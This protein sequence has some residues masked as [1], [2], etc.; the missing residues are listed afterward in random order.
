[1]TIHRN[2]LKSYAPKARTAFIAA[3]SARAAQFG[4]TADGCFPMTEEGDVVIIDG[5]AY[6]RSVANQR[7]DLEA[8]IRLHGFTQAMEEIAYTWFN[9]F[10]A[11][12]YM[13][14]QEGTYFDH[15]YR[16]LSHPDGGDKPE[17]LQHAEHLELAGLDRDRVVDLRLDGTKDEELYRMILVAQCN[18]LHAAMPF[19]FEKID[20]ETELLLPDHLLRSDSLINDLVNDIDE[21]NW[22]EIEIIGW[23]YQF[24][25][26][27][28][29]DEVIGKVV[30]S[31]DI[32][33]ATQLFTPNWIVKYMV[34]NSLGHQWL[35]TYP[36]SPLKGKMEYYIEPAEQTEEVQAQLAEITPTELNPEELT[37]LDPAAGSGH[38]LVEAYDLF[39]EIYLE[40]GYRR[41]DVPRLILEKN[42]YGLDI[43][44][45]AAQMAG[46]ALIMKACA[47]TQNILDPDNPVKLNVMSIQSSEGLD[48]AQLA[49]DLLPEGGRFEIV[50]SDELPGLETQPMLAVNSTSEVR[51]GT[52]NTLIN[53]FEEAKTFGSLITV[54]E[55]VK[56]ALPAFKRLMNQSFEG[57]MLQTQLHDDAV[58]KLFPL[59]K[60]AE[61]LTRLYDAVVANPPYMGAGGMVGSLKDF[62]TSYFAP[63]K[64]DLYACFLIRCNNFLKNN[65]IQSQINMHTW[66]F[67]P[68]YEDL[69]RLIVQNFQLDTLLHLGSR[70]FEEISG[71]VVQSATWVMRKSKVNE[72]KSQYIKLTQGESYTKQS[73]L[74]NKTYDFWFKDQSS[75]EHLPSCSISYDMP[76]AL[77]DVY[78]RHSRYSDY[79]FSDGLTKTGNND[80]YLRFHWEIQN[81]HFLDID[82]FRICHKGGE[83]QEFYGNNLNLVC[84][85]KDIRGHYKS[86][87]VARITPE[88]LWN[89]S[90]I[91][92]TKISSK[93]PSFRLMEEGHIGE[94]GG[95]VIF[96]KD[97]K[98]GTNYKALMFLNSVVSR[99]ILSIANRSLNIQTNDVLNL[100][101]IEIKSQKLEDTAKEVIHISKINWDSYETSW[102]F[103]NAPLLKE[104]VKQ[105]T[106]EESF[107]NWQ[108]EC[109][110]NVQRI[111]ELEEENNRLCIAEYCLQD[112]LSPDVSEE[113]IT[114][115]RADLKQDIKNLISYSIGCMMGRYSLVEEGLIY[116]NAGNV[117]FDGSRYGEFPADDDGIVPISG[118]D[119]LAFDDD[120]AIRFRDFLKIA[121]SEEN[122]NANLQ[123]VGESLGLKKAETPQDAIRS[124]LSKDFYKDHLK[125]YK[126]RPIYWLFSSGKLKAFECL[127]YLHRYNEG[128]LARMRME[129]VTPLQSRM[130]N[131]IEMLSED[132]KMASSA[133]AKKKQTEKDNLSKQLEE[134][135]K[136][137]E[138]LRHYADKRISLDLDDGVKVN[139]G[140]F[141]NLLAETKAITGKKK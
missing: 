92:W 29:K 72:Y 54:P 55:N 3:V 133:E 141:G 33:A 81:T 8:R 103:K 24:Y 138:E 65:G 112:E 23:L 91:T 102:G 94:T 56:Q 121:W 37:L 93:S 19:L 126:K 105:K 137:D 117:G 51:E 82:K 36:L 7:R 10:M 113:H 32:P 67:L 85:T 50:P 127:V 69:R 73:N 123:F 95:P 27:E 48:A 120:A 9:R 131:R 18:A 53:L 77:I 6:P 57:D 104:K 101:Y 15:G 116:A 35:A 4:V 41:R 58:N 38:I 5:T 17:I 135:R 74:L 89:T 11:I 59:V 14:L 98:I 97:N 139:Y 64:S 140:K 70:A 1:M 60:Q 28:K 30:K 87:K 45:R 47:D 130:T 88:Y 52:F 39:K 110:A 40:R 34:Q 25:I 68:A 109:H 84:W 119:A 26:S 111:K 80:K 46:F 79:F 22:E 43:D 86:D 136:F 106:L 16:V 71:E 13:E 75:Y 42:L 12:R 44:D 62:V 61:I 66:M 108:S 31:E 99:Y 2:Q 21:E 129:Y 134:L 96:P 132:I 83:Y 78:N 107:I 100:P 128:T 125:T 90:G 76:S 115:T 122:L 49:R 114:L 118:S 63:A 124:Y 20:D